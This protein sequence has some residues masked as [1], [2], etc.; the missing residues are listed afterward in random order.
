M[1]PAPTPFADRIWQYVDR[2]PHD[3]CWLWTAGCNSLGYGR[4][5]E[6]GRDLYAHRVVYE[7]LIGPIPDGTELDHLC[8]T[9]AC[10]NPRH[11]EPVTHRENIRR[12]HFKRTEKTHC[13]AGHPYSGANLWIGRRGDG[14]T[15]RMCRSCNNGR[16]HAA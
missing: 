8:R 15:F 9:P 2:T 3:G 10:V 4:T 16:R 5:S 13:P 12:G 6:G 7:L 14:R 11:L 1:P